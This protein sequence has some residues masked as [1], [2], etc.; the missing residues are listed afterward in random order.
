MIFHKE[1]RRGYWPIR[2]RQFVIHSTSNSVCQSSISD[3]GSCVGRLC[4]KYIKGASVDPEEPIFVV[5]ISA[6][7]VGGGVSHRFIKVGSNFPRWILV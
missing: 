6:K 2:R 1:K 3:Q 4:E 7:G 5:T